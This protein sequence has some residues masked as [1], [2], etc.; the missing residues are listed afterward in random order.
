MKS[1]GKKFEE[2]FQDSAK[3]AMFI[4]RLRDPASSFN[5]K[6]Q[7]CPKQVTRFSFKNICD[8]IA[9]DYQNTFLL[10]LKSTNKKSFPFANIIKDKKDKRLESMVKED[11]AYPYILSYVI[12]NFRS[13]DNFTYAVPSKI[14]LN[15]IETAPRKSIP[16]AWIAENGIE[17]KSQI[18]RV[19]YRYYIKQFLSD[20]KP[21]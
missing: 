15:Y 7:G 4:Y 16:F 12:F 10:E 11:D 19:R 6:C 1:E 5:L 13:D 3:Q 8:F 18:K 20:I 2:D 21:F 9:A 17:I 14:V